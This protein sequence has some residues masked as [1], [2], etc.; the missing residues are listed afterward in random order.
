[1]FL[2]TYEDGRTAYLVVE[3]H[4]GPEEDFRALAIARQRQ[5]VGELPEGTIRTVKRVR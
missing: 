3:G 5:H 1:M 4:G 2:A